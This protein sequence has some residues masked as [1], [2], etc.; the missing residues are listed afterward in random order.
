MLA[1]SFELQGVED[2]PLYINYG[3]LLSTNH[4]TQ[5]S[6]ATVDSPT[7]I[8]SKETCCLRDRDAR[9]ALGHSEILHGGGLVHVLLH[10]AEVVAEGAHALRKCR[11][12]AFQ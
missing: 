5:D 6:I 7:P 3:L 9:A 4:V 8:T 2:G 12:S 1:T 10:I 11:A